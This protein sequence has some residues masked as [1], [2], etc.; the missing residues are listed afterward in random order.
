MDVETVRRWVSEA[1]RIV[2]F[3][4]AGISTES[5]IP[6]FRSP[7]GVWARNRMIEFDEFVSSREGRVEY[8]RQKAEPGPPCATL[9]RTPA[10]RLSSNCTATAVSPP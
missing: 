6:D 3:S 7:N 9:G 5:G 2:G 8:W 10:T 1:K 4:G